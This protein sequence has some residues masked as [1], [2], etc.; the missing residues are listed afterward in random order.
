MK[1]KNQ[2]NK[3]LGIVKITYITVEEFESIIMHTVKY[4]ILRRGMD[5]Q[6]E[7]SVL[8]WTPSTHATKK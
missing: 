3:L 2:Y 7:V 1:R 4:L 6:S 5:W 8:F